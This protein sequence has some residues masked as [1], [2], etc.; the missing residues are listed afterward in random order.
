MSIDYSRE[1]NTINED[2][3][4]QRPLLEPTS[5]HYYT[6]SDQEGR[7]LAGLTVLLDGE[8]RALRAELNFHE[9]PPV[10]TQNSLIRQAKNIVM[11][12][13]AGSGES[14]EISIMESRRQEAALVSHS[15][16]PLYRKESSYR[17][18]PIAASIGILFLVVLVVVLMVLF[19]RGGEETTASAALPTAQPTATPTVVAGAPPGSVEMQSS[20]GQTYYATTNGLP[21]SKYADARLAPGDN[22]RIRRG[23]ASFVRSEPGATA[24]EELVAIESGQGGQIVGGPVWLQGDQD[25]IVWWFLELDDS[26]IQGWAPANTSEMTVLEPA[27]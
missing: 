6:L 15:G 17:L 16:A 23:L 2:F 22:A 7:L 3:Q 24:G 14:T 27:R 19:F 10:Q 18:W 1:M 21:T 26:G 13:Y 20:D 12:N 8:M 11:R 25:T 9:N 5:A 4:Q